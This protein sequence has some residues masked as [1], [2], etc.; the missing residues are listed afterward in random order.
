MFFKP[1]DILYCGVDKEKILSAKPV[2]NGDNLKLLNYWINERDSIRIK[3]NS[4]FPA[5]WTDDKIL[6]KYRFCNVR[7]ENDRESQWLID[8]IVNNDSL[9]YD[10]KLLDIILFRLINK[11][12]TTEIFGLINFSS[13]DYSG[14]S[15]I[16]DDYKKVNPYYVFFSNAFF[17]SGPKTI[18][19]KLFGKNYDMV[20]KMIMLVEYYKN[21]G[22]INKVINSKSQLEVYHSLI[23]LPGIGSFLAYQIFVDFTY[24]DDFPFSE[25]E[26]TIAGPGC[27]SGLKLLFSDFDDLSYEELLFWLRDK[28][29]LLDGNNS[30]LSVMSLENCMCEF[31][32]Y[33]RAKN[34]LGRPRILYKTH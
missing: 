13:I 10:N 26:F 11:S 5:P 16:L 6:M 30:P 2:I 32:K 19:N 18:S 20:I 15:K 14:I 9:S 28:I 22:I 31:S 4:G 33:W 34:N 21:L 1:R 27:I 23:S 12:Q 7:R 8:N 25:E 17:T 3:K 24:I 29:K